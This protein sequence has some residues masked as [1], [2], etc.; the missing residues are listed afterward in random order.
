MVSVVERSGTVVVVV[1]HQVLVRPLPVATVDVPLQFLV[2]GRRTGAV[3]RGARAVGRGALAEVGGVLFVVG[4]A[5]AEVWGPLA[6]VA[7]GLSGAQGAPLQEEK[8]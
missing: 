4:G 7:A 1:D 6:V 8:Y 3:G 5:L 2:V